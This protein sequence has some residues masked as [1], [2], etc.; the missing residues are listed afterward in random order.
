MNTLCRF[1]DSAKLKVELTQ[2]SRN[3]ITPSQRDD[4]DFTNKIFYRIAA[5]IQQIKNL[6][7]MEEILA[8]AGIPPLKHHSETPDVEMKNGEGNANPSSQHNSSK[9]TQRQGST[10]TAREDDTVRTPRI[11]STSFGTEIIDLQPI[12]CSCIFNLL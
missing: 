6:P 4:E 7:R 2:L 10:K 3:E 8:E 9:G 5:C 1:N 12:N 11:P